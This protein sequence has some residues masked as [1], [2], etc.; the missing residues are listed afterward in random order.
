MALLSISAHDID[1]SGLAVQA[2]LPLVWLKEEL[3]DAD[4]EGAVPG[5]VDVR[6]SRSGN[7]VVVRG[8]VTADLRT[9]CARCLAPARVAID[10][11]LSLL[12][13]PRPTGAAAHPHAHPKQHA[14]GAANGA[15]KPR[16]EK[17][18]EYEFTSEEADVDV[19]DGETV[20][21]DPFVREA[22]LLEVPNFPLCS[23]DCP[24]IR[25][26]APAEPPEEAAPRVD[27]RLA[28]LG[29]LR[30]KL[31]AAAKAPSK[32]PP[33]A[34]ERLGASG[35]AKKKTKSAPAKARTP[36]VKAAGKKTK[37]DKE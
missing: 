18:D 34:P 19:F 28:P 6:L 9:P 8:K 23:E 13:Q 35:P 24:G 7:D 17:E 14:N 33:A 27:P 5:R 37:K 32:A 26:A 10:T 12:L 4:L 36:A 1:A 20:V 2:E 16:D 21:L 31:Q 3:A 22:I 25:P 30:D 15:K 29:A 11:D